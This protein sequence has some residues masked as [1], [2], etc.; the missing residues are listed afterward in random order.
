MQTGQRQHCYIDFNVRDEGAF[1]RLAVVVDEF[2]RQKETSGIFDATHWL[3][4]FENSERA[5][6]WWPT[7]AELE[8]WN[9]FWLSTP[10]PQRYS[11]TMP[12]PPWHFVS[13]VESVLR[14][15]FDLIGVQKSHEKRGRLEFYPHGYPY[16]GTGSL[17]ALVRAFGH[18]V[19]GYDDGTGFVAGDAQPPRWTP[20]TKTR[21]R[22]SRHRRD[23]RRLTLC[24]ISS[25]L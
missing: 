11:P 21:D 2:Q 17:R 13:M 3:P 19:T 6:F 12:T 1:R 22:Q 23:A 20:D 10:Y 18:E 15:D 25:S 9:D 5:E 16:G 14:G 8:Q 7:E 4:Y 24:P